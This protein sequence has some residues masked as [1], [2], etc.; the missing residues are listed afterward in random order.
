MGN[1]KRYLLKILF[2]GLIVAAPIV[3]CM[4]MIFYLK[5]YLTDDRVHSA[6]VPV[7]QAVS[8]RDLLIGDTEFQLGLRSVLTLREV[9]FLADDPTYPDTQFTAAKFDR[10]TLQFKPLTLFTRVFQIDSLIVEG[11]QGTL[12]IDSSRFLPPFVWTNGVNG[13]P[14]EVRIDSRDFENMEITVLRISGGDLLVFDEA[15]QKGLQIDSFDFNLKLEGI[16]VMRLLLLKGETSVEFPQSASR[17]NGVLLRLSGRFQFN[18]DDQ[19]IIIRNGILGINGTESSFTGMVQ[20]E[21]G[22]PHCKIFIDQPRESLESDILKLPQY[23]RDW[24]NGSLPHSRFS[25]QFVYPDDDS[26]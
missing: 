17:V 22:V 8:G 25:I 12:T 2:W 14:V 24:L 21:N 15:S 13:R 18:M 9:R 1:V 10:F 19:S 26:T 11:L 6:V 3:F 20:R 7:L 4:M 23:V 16:R 5:T